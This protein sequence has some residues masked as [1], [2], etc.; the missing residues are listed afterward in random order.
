[1]AGTARRVDRRAPDTSDPFALFA[2]H[3]VTRPP[4]A[5]PMQLNPR[6]TEVTSV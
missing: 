4:R 6:F 1:M 2:L 3:V 5:P